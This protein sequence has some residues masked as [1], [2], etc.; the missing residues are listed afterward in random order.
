MHLNTD[1]YSMCGIAGIIQTDPSAYTKEQLKKMTDALAHRGPDGEG[2]WEDPANRALLGHRRL[3]I[4]DLSDAGCQPLH[5]LE[6]YTIIHN[7][8]IYNYI[9]LREELAKKGYSFHSQTDTEVIAAAYDHWE[10][11]CVLHFDGMFSFAIWDSTKK[12]LFA[13]RDRFGEK[14]FFYYFDQRQLVFAS[15][16]KALWAAGVKRTPNQKMLF[17]FITIGYT[18]NPAQPG[19][20]FFENIYKLPAATTLTYSPGDKEPVLE[21]YWDIDPELQNKKISDEQ[22]LEQ[23][24][25]LLTTSVKRRLRSDVSV[26]TS[27]S[28]GLDSSSI[29]SMIH[30]LSAGNYSKTFTAVFPGFEKNELACSQQV[31]DQFK[32]EQFTVQLSEAD[33]LKDWEKIS[34]HQ[35]E[36]FGS[37]SIIA[38]YKVYELARQQGVKVLLDGQGA[39]EILAGYSKYYKWYWQELFR[40]R[41]LY[42]SK[43]LKAA[44]EV[45]IGESFN[46]KNMIAA[47]FPAFATVMLENQ[48]LLKSIRQPDLTKE[49]V[50]LQS[51]EAYYTTPDHFTL[52]GVLHFNTCI[53][54][55]EE[56]LRY[57]DRNAMANGREVRLPFLSHELVE[58]LFT[59]PS[60]YKIRGGWT[61][62]LLRKTMD[63]KLPAE[64]T[65][66]RDKVGFEPPQKKWMEN[67]QVQEA[68]WEAKKKLVGEKVL[69]PEVLDRPVIPLSSHDA[70]NYDWRYFSAAGLFK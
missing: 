15:E 37:A 60:H 56:L 16:M 61:K 1:I 24:H 52:N 35:E 45:G 12:N 43:E 2:L 46:Y 23:F 70:D 68:I 66:R 10:D 62:W 30:D 40:N 39:D 9:E 67:K 36:P 59:L 51:K 53:H 41:R 4:I 54:G 55:L 38:Q 5:Y 20:T 3:S 13:A 18:D 21:Q 7:G 31:A 42:R 32:L 50:T 28:G 63:K 6:R 33:L 26:G 64:I 29:V 34:Y 22:A 69:K 47:Y 19:E 58:F 11:D 27:L 17:N 48:Y 8:E 57:A 49:F 25:H 65:W 14:P 44:K